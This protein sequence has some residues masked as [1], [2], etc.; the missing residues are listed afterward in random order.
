[1]SFKENVKRKLSGVF[2][3]KAA[4]VVGDAAVVG[5]IA[6][7]TLAGAALATPL[8]PLVVVTGLAATAIWGVLL[9][10]DVSK[11]KKERAAK[12]NLGL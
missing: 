3:F 6:A 2:N 1:M 5:I 10:R 8:A 4:R 12:K 9:K 11:W 7:K